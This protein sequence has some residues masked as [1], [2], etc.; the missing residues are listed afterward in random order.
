MRL[1]K[2]ALQPYGHRRPGVFSYVAKNW[3]LDDVLYSR[4][5]RDDLCLKIFHSKNGLWGTE[6]R[7]YDCSIAQNVFAFDG[8]APRVYDLIEVEKPN[9]SRITRK[10]DG[11]TAQV[12]DYVF[13]QSGVRPDNELLESVLAKY[14][15]KIRWDMNKGNVIAGQLVDFQ[16]AYLD[17]AAYQQQVH[18]LVKAH[19]AWGSREEPYQGLDGAQRN[20]GHR[21]DLMCLDDFDFQGKDVLDVGCNLGLFCWFAAESGAR[22]VVGVDLPDTVS[23]ARHYANLHGRWAI[24]FVGA[25]LPQEKRKI[26]GRYDVVFCLS[27]MQTKPFPWIFDLV[28]PGGYFFFEGHV[29]SHEETYRSIFEEHFPLVEFLGTSRDHGPRPVFRCIK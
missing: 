18:E 19:C 10:E 11:K 28:K 13:G 8:L 9:G 3:A 2:Q 29:P 5:G 16:S 14:P 24:D 15:V 6:N 17:I 1:T 22:R 12:T 7:I 4:Y 21:R 20:F 25:A 26:K 27:A 23:A